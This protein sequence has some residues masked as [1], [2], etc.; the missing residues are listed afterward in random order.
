[1]DSDKS[2]IFFC[3]LHDRPSELT[4]QLSQPMLGV[5]SECLSLA[6]QQCHVDAV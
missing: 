5:E 6:I 4:M 3:H 1:M 2:D